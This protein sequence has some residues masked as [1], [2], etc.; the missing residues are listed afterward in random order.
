MTSAVGH[1]QAPVAGQHVLQAILI[2]H[3]G[4]RDLYLSKQTQGIHQ[5]MAFAPFDLFARVV[6]GCLA[7][8]CRLDRLAIH[9]PGLRGRRTTLLAAFPPSEPVENGSP[10]SVACPAIKAAIH[11]FPRTKRGR[12]ERPRTTRFSQIQHPIYHLAR[13]PSRAA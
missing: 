1:P 4:G 11:G 9:A 13:L 8:G 12:Q 2:A 5:Q 10:D 3:I 7:M 6:T